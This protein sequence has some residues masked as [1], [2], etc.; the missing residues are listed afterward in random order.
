M[1]L[2]ERLDLVVRG[3]DEV[4]TEGELKTLLETHDRPSCYIGFEPSGKAHAGW[5][6]LARK[7]RDL[8]AAGFHVKILLADWHAYINDK[9]AGDIETIRA[10]G[11]YMEHVFK[12]LDVGEVEVVWA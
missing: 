11:R 9:F 2:Y 1:D 6:I 5:L 4:I 8:N 10:N 7:L 3:A 12:A